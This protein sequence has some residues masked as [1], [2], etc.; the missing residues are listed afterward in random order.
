MFVAPPL[1][2]GSLIAEQSVSGSGENAC[3]AALE[4]AASGQAPERKSTLETVTE[5]PGKALERNGESVGE[6]LEGLGE[7]LKN[8]FGN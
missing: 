5:D 3:V 6:T 7:S 2:L 1:A 8:L 4:A